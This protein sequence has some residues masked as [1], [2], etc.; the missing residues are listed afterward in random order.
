MPVGDIDAHSL[1]KNLE[2]NGCF[3]FAFYLL[4]HMLFCFFSFLL[5]EI[6]HTIDSTLCSPVYSKR[7]VLLLLP[8]TAVPRVYARA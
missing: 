6:Y 4:P 7:S 1:S 8:M 2:T 5:L 3:P